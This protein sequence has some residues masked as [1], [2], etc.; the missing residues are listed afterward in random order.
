MGENADAR[1]A[2]SPLNLSLFLPQCCILLTLSCW[3]ETC[4]G[5][6]ALAFFGCTASFMIS[7]Q[8]RFVALLEEIY[9]NCGCVTR[10]SCMIVFR[11]SIKG[12][13]NWLY[14]SIL[15]I[16]ACISSGG[17]TQSHCY[18][19]TDHYCC[20]GRNDYNFYLDE[21]RCW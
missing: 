2:G 5:P 12:V 17:L 20:S 1:A 7:C 3:T 10:T 13:C 16:S 21:H 9:N 15:S 4:D 6:L 14:N 11:N 8:L 18:Y 19:I